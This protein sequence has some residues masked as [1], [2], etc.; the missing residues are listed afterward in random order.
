MRH[1]SH[2]G[3]Q[4]RKLYAKKLSEPIYLQGQFHARFKIKILKIKWAEKFSTFY[5]QCEPVIKLLRWLS[6]QDE[7]IYSG[8]FSFW[9]TCVFT[10]NFF[11]FLTVGIFVNIL[12]SKTVNKSRVGFRGGMYIRGCQMGMQGPQLCAKPHHFCKLDKATSRMA[13]LDL[14]LQVLQVATSNSNN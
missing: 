12:C 1:K 11:S 7:I 8:E 2:D 6:Q 13:F 3:L 4:K 14:N 10:R 5:A 9:C